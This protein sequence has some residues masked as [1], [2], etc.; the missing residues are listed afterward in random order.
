MVAQ[1][2]AAG[3]REASVA[4]DAKEA[5][6]ELEGSAA[7][8]EEAGVVAGEVGRA[9]GARRVRVTAAVVTACVHGSE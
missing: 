2:A 4:E 8:L 5:V 1:G 3:Q 9:E 6:M 7:A